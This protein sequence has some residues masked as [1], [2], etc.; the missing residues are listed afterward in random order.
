M[1]ERNTQKPVLVTEDTT[2]RTE[3]PVLVEVVG[4]IPAAYLKTASVS[5]N[6]LTLTK[7][8]DTTVSFSP[9]CYIPFPDEFVTNQTTY[10]FGQSVLNYEG[11]KAGTAWL[12]ELRCTD[13]PTDLNNV[14]CI[15]T[16]L[17]DGIALLQLSSSNRSP[18]HWEYNTA[19]YG[20]TSHD[21]WKLVITLTESDMP[22][23]ATAAGTYTVKMDFDGTNLYNFKLVKDE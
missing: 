12:G 17:T 9:E 23:G 8:D 10:D 15:V 18:Y 2:N 5:E 11:F 7:Q 19:S 14:E 21:G 16:G 13:L 6:T 22:T 3:K 1:S 4:G 20:S